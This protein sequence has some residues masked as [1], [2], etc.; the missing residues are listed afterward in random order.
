MACCVFCEIEFQSFAGKRLWSNS[1]IK[2]YLMRIHEELF[3]FRFFC[4][5]FCTF[6]ECWPHI[7]YVVKLKASPLLSWAKLFFSLSLWTFHFSFGFEAYEKPWNIYNVA[8]CVFEHGYQKHQDEVEALL[9]SIFQP[10]A[11]CGITSQLGNLSSFVF[12]TVQS[13][14][15]GKRRSSIWSPANNFCFS[16]IEQSTRMPSGSGLVANRGRPQFP[17]HHYFSR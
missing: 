4:C 7:P 5:T 2:Q 17:K 13:L 14:G 11:N 15:K 9:M 1:L 12:L 16:A 10:S 3:C 6:S 8:L